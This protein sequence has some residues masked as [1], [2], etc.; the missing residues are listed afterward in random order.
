MDEHV[1]FT[2]PLWIRAFGGRPPRG[3]CCW[4]CDGRQTSCCS[5][6]QA[7]VGHRGI[8]ASSREVQVSH[9]FALLGCRRCD[10]RA[11]IPPRGARDRLHSPHPD[12]CVVESEPG[13]GHGHK[14]RVLSAAPPRHATRSRQAVVALVP[15]HRAQIPR[16]VV[17]G[18]PQDPHHRRALRSRHYPPLRLRR[19]AHGRGWRC[20]A[21]AERQRLGVWGPVARTGGREWREGSPSTSA[22]VAVGQGRGRKVQARG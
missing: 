3:C 9:S 20:G 14:V 17:G 1:L 2:P 18:P 8:G 15:D 7:R 5:Q 11:R 4:N 19:G 22:Q 10:P 6:A 21:V 12:A 16:A 13:G